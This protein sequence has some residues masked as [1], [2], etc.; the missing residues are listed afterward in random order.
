MFVEG[1]MVVDRQG[2]RATSIGSFGVSCEGQ[3]KKSSE[4]TGTW[5]ARGRNPGK[6]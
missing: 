2:H 4:W 1:R 5:R 6:V 3:T